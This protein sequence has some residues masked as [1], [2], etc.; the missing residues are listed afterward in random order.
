MSVLFSWVQFL[1]T[2]AQCNPQPRTWP[3]K[4]ERCEKLGLS[5][6]EPLRKNRRRGA[7]GVRGDKAEARN[8]PQTPPSTSDE[9]VSSYAGNEWD[10]TDL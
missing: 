3:Q 7:K 5:C 9:L 4:C 1:L 8:A 6:T 2:D 10:M